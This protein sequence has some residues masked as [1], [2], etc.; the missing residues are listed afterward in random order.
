MSSR[1]LYIIVF[2]SF[3]LSVGAQVL[4]ESSKIV[5]TYGIGDYAPIWHNANSQGV[6]SM[7]NSSVYAR[8][9]VGGEHPFFNNNLELDWGVDAVGGYNVTSNIFVQQA[10]LDEIALWEPLLTNE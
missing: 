1:L 2:F 9:G 3:T 7:N 4:H 8:L 5:A 10:F 6:N